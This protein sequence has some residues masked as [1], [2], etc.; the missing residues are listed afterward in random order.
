MQIEDF[1]PEVYGFLV[2]YPPKKRAIVVERLLTYAIKKMEHK[3]SQR[4]E[5]KHVCEPSW[6][7]DQEANVKPSTS[8]KG[9]QSEK[10]NNNIN[11][12]DC[13]PKR[14]VDEMTQTSNPYIT[15]PKPAVKGSR[16]YKKMLAGKNNPIEPPPIEDMMMPSLS[17][18]KKKSLRSERQ[19][20]YAATLNNLEESEEQSSSSSQSSSY[21]WNKRSTKNA[22]IV[23]D[24]CADPFVVSSL[25]KMTLQKPLTFETRAS[26][27]NVRS[28]LPSPKV[29]PQKPNG[30]P[31]SNSSKEQQQ[32]PPQ[33]S[34][35]KV[36]SL[37][38]K[39]IAINFTS[40]PS[41]K[42]TADIAREFLESTF[43]AYLNPP[44]KNDNQN[45]EK[46]GND[47]KEIILKAREK[48]RVKEENYLI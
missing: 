21:S 48:V 16:G 43:V 36:N 46:S 11:N 25:K 33:Q 20:Y 1:P 4:Q 42:S 28:I 47:L 14:M 19:L 31:N 27:R 45:Y 40:I 30:K 26:S 9:K 22:E 18:K 8:K 3:V 17:S 23:P 35:L 24:F 6:W 10:H 41:S 29:V 34:K 5:K 15:G 44:A 7:E 2:K 12:D 37:N 39:K 13:F 38:E 32:K